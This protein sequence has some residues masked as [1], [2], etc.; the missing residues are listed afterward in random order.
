M[1]ED[2]VNVP[3]LAFKHDSSFFR[4]IA[5]GAVG[6][7]A[8][9]EDLGRRGHEPVELERGSADTKIWK[10]VKRKRVRIPDVVCLRCG[11][12]AESRA[13]TKPGL[14]MSHSLEAERAW[15]YG[16]VDDDLVAIPICRVADEAKWA[17]GRLEDGTSYWHER[18]WL[19]W[20]A[21]PYVNYFTVADLRATAP[22]KSSTKGVTEGF[23]TSLAW[24]AIFSTRSGTVK[25][26]DD[27][28]IQIATPGKSPYR[29]RNADG[30][31]VRV[32]AGQ[33]VTE[34][35]VLASSVP[36]AHNAELGC[37]GDLSASRVEE[38]LRS[39]ER[40]QRFTGVKVARLL[41]QIEHH[42][43]VA[44]LAYDGE[45]DFYVRL[46]GVAYLLACAGEPADRLLAPYLESNDESAQLE[47]V[48]TLGEIG[49]PDAVALLSRML[50]DDAG[51][52][53]LRS[54]AA[55]ALGQVGADAA[56]ESLVGA[57]G[58]LDHDLRQEALEGVAQIGQAAARHLVGGLREGDDVASGCAEVLRRLGARDPTAVTRSVVE[59]GR[60]ESSVWPVW[61]LGQLPRSSVEEILG[62]LSVS[63]EV[64]YALKVLWTFAESWVA[65]TWEPSPG[66]VFPP[67]PA[68]AE[69]ANA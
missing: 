28:T 39:R 44:A 41:D 30:L 36:P 21:F 53:F 65:E 56:V 18:N 38:L 63:P 32:E 50:H 5:T 15:D 61:L 2:G 37:P 10:E 60:L 24:D 14:S 58:A 48:I 13:K 69:E 43:A 11:R 49:T 35:Q 68:E 57:F 20:E 1:S 67:R 22:T 31:P 59:G 9:L 46:E 40:T 62:G 51:P 19:R 27:G 66:A 4:K 16:M 7:R 26:V 12:R 55:W 52:F 42:D 23:E 45:E 6:T 8:V 54:A 25:D 34:T 64:D 17:V 33:K 29:W 47:A 3:R